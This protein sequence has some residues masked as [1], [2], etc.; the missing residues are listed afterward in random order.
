MKI[1]NFVVRVYNANTSRLIESIP[2]SAPAEYWREF[3]LT[4]VFEKNYRADQTK[5]EFF[6][7]LG[8]GVTMWINPVNLEVAN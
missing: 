6:H 3:G 4:K 8:D 7:D 5:T 2:Y 1:N